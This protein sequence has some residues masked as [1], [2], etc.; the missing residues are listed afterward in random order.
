MSTKSKVIAV[1]GGMGCGQ[2]TVCNF[3]ERMGARVINADIEAKREIESNPE[4]K[5][6]L[7]SAFGGRVFYQNGK[8]NRK[9]L[10]QIA[11]S[12][13]AKTQR[14]NK[15][16]HPQM[17]S[18]VIEKIESARESGKYK[19]IAVDAALVYEINLEHMFDAVVVVAAKMK[20]RIERIKQ[21]DRLSEKEVIN[22]INKQ[23]PIDEKKK[24]A[25][26]VVNNYSSLEKLE[27]LT[28]DLYRKLTGTRRRPKIK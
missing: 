1:T 16:V 15:I 13:V 22:R 23:I 26:F 3:L 28:R 25:D 9:Y 18:R 11:F 17:V 8:L 19:I 7:R 24:W 6:E 20:D 14:L 12:D 4:I 21:R 5:K 10:V 2:S 27:E